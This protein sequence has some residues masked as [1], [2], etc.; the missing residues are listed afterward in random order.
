VR[1]PLD[2]SSVDPIPERLRQ[3]LEGA[4]PPVP[5]DDVVP[6]EPEHARPDV[7][8]AREPALRS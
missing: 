1:E 7:P 4:G 2:W 3:V 5:L 6:G 8:V